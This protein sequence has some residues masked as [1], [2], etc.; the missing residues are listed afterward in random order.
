[1]VDIIALVRAWLE[2]F[3]EGDFDGFPGRVSEEFTLRLPFLPPGLPTEYRGR[4]AAR[5]ALA[6]SARHRSPLRFF[7]VE[8]LRT[9]DP[10]RVLV[11]ARG[12]ATLADGR[13]YRNDYLMLVR[14]RGDEVVEHVEY[15]NPLALS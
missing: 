5:A 6:A 4:E 1:M 9:E 8:I 3:A 13:P 10:E 15:L 14:I 11:I 12:Q 2:H 7:D